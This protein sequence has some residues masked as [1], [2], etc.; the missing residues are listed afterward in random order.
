LLFIDI[1]KTTAEV[2]G[3]Y[4]LLQFMTVVGVY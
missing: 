4:E 1:C 3:V 2:G